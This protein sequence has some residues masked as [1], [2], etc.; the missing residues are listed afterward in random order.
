VVLQVGFLF[1]VWC[2]VQ[3]K[4]AYWPTYKCCLSVAP[5]RLRRPG[6]FV[7]VRLVVFYTESL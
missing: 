5:G 1:G 6:V 7:S 2:L 3:Y 4:R